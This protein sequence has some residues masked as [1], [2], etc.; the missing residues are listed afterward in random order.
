MIRRSFHYHIPPETPQR[1]VPCGGSA[2]SRGEVLCS[3]AEFR[4]PHADTLRANDG[5]GDQECPAPH[6]PDVLRA[7]ANRLLN[8]RGQARHPPRDLFRRIQARERV[9][10]RD[11]PKPFVPPSVELLSF[12]VESGL[13]MFL[14]TFPDLSR[15]G[16]AKAW[17]HP[18]F[19]LGGG[20]DEALCAATL[21]GFWRCPPREV[22]SAK[23]NSA[24]RA[25]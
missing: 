14:E 13:W 4:P 18:R 9:W 7:L 17:K 3:M 2:G 20:A 22:G 25:S 21:A 15:A 5:T 1:P 6:F 19:P 11:H 16:T 23:P 8:D 24:L 10:L 12:P